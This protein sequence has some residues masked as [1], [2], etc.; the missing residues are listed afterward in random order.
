MPILVL[1]LEAIGAASGL[2]VAI[3]LG[4]SITT[5]TVLT[6]V[7]SERR[8]SAAVAD[9]VGRTRA[10]DLQR[11]V[12]DAVR[13]ARRTLR[14]PHAD[15]AMAAVVTDGPR[16]LATVLLVALGLLIGV[17]PIERPSALAAGFVIAAV[18]CTSIAHVALSG[19]RIRTGDRI[20]WTYS[21]IGEI[22]GRRDIDGVA[23][24]SWMG[25]IATIVGINVAVALR[26]MSDRWTH[27]LPAMDDES[28]VVAMV[29]GLVLAVGALVTLATTAAPE[30]A[31]AHLVA[32][33]LEERTARQSVLA[34]AVGVG[35][36]GL[37]AGVL[38]GGVQATDH[39]RPGSNTFP[40]SSDQALRGSSMGDEVFERAVIHTPP[41]LGTRSST[42]P[43]SRMSDRITPEC[44]TTSV[45][46]RPVAAT[47]AAMPA[48]AAVAR[49]T[50]A[51][52]G[53]KVGGRRC[54]PSQPGQRRSISLGVRPSHSP[55]NASR[56]PGT[57]FGPSSPSTSEMMAA[58]SAARL[59][60][61][62]HTVSTPW[63]SVASRLAVWRCLFAAYLVQGRIGGP[64]PAPH[65][66]PLALAVP[67]QQDR[68]G[69]VGG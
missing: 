42:V 56:N 62:D 28:R 41:R 29:C 10:E 17:S 43:S 16:R 54:A 44:A 30:L 5:R 23:P 45:E 33:R 14:R 49:S 3:A 64:L 31:N 26:G 67:K 18:M 8:Y 9:V 59:R 55:A 2:V 34:A 6:D 57:N 47:A 40:S 60:S 66:V 36:I 68:D 69:L 63:S 52:K 61:L 4:R 13:S 51:S 35:M 46:A 37:V 48:S 11:T 21:T 12:R 7:P 38:P 50:T 20:R 32:R 39:D 53:S 15:Y 65:S 24:R 19:G 1:L 58:V 25:T 27:G 22:V